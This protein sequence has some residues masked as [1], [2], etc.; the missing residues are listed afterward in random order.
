[1]EFYDRGGKPNPHLD[2]LIQPR[3]LSA[4][5]KEALVEFLKCLTG[6]VIFY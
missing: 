1:V 2:A 6:D 5:E 3:R 4:Q